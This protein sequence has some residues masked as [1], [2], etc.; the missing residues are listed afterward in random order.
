MRFKKLFAV[1]ALTAA[2]ALGL[3]ACNDEDNNGTSSSVRILHINDHH[4]HLKADSADLMLAGKETE[5]EVGGFPRVVSQFRDRNLPS[6]TLKL[7]A[8][9]A[10]TGTLFYT[11]FQGEAD[12]DMM[13]QVCFDAFA[14]GNHEFDDGDAGLKKFLDFLNKDGASCNTPVLAA[15]VMP[16]VGV[17]PLAQ[18]SATDYIQPYTILERQGKKYGVIG[19]DIANKTKNSSNPDDSTQFLDEVETA[20]EYINELSA[21]GIS[22]II[23]LT[24]YQYQNDLELAKNLHGVDVI[25]GGDSHSLL[26]DKFEELGLAPQGPY[27]TQASNKDGQPVCIAQAWQYSTV[28][29]ELNVDF[30]PQGVV[31]NCAGTPHMLLGDTFQREDAEGEDYE[32][33]GAEKQAVMADISQIDELSV[34]APDQATSSALKQFADRVEVLQEQRIGSASQDLCLERIPGQ[35]RSTLDGCNDRTRSNGSD[36]SNVVAKAFL[37]MSNTSDIAIQNAGGVRIDVPAGDITIGTAYT[38]LPFSNTLMEIEMTGQEIVDVLEEAVVF[39]LDGSTGAYPYAA[40][41]RWDIDM[42]KPAGQRF[43]N[44][45]VNPRVAGSWTPI[46]LN[47]TYKIVTNDFIAAGR[48]GYITFGELPDERKTDTFLDYAKSFVD[49]VE[50]E[51]EAGRTIDRLP[52]KEYSTQNFINSNGELQK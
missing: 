27:P 7:H 31:T 11:L 38:L 16:E 14:L 42:S 1:S 18:E 39:A 28:V 25:I 30:D 13:N 43:S 52:L 32:L 40:G 51:T 47:K 5:V 3:S 12:A 20:Q 19:I 37:E 22:K 8:G 49:Y 45:E 36:I 2:I 24:H 17:S 33:S 29:G 26:G 44:V 46:D 4:S 23:L 35:G 50:R 34:V 9:D 10:I 21:Q 6:N 48:D 41:L 15:N